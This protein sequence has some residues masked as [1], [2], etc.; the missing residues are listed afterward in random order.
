[1]PLIFIYTNVETGSRIR[2]ILGMQDS[3][4]LYFDPASEGAL[5]NSISML[6]YYYS[7]RVNNVNL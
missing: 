1:M 6:H 7:T 5:I 4:G 3:E 2:D